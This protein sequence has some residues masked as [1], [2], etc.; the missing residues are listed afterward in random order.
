MLIAQTQQPLRSVW[1]TG[2]WGAGLVA[3]VL[4]IFFLVHDES[5]VVLPVTL[6][7]VAALGFSLAVWLER[8]DRRRRA[9]IANFETNTLRLDFVTPI[10]GQPKTMIIAFDGVKAVD[11][12]EQGDGRQCLFV[13][14][15]RSATSG[16]FREVLVACIESDEFS[17]ALR[18]QRVLSG[19]FGLGAPR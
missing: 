19:A 14:F 7:A 3:I 2:A 6:G 18:L 13:D 15:E 17:S 5:S 16:V 4:A 10:A 9:F 12:C 1:P 11:F 8:V